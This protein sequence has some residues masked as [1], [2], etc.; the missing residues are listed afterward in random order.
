MSVKRI[1]SSWKRKQVK[2]VIRKSKGPIFRY[3]VMK[4]LDNVRGGPLF[5]TENRSGTRLMKK[6]SKK[7][8]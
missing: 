8:H 3:R 2:N 6:Q 5:K 4:G 7:K 1:S